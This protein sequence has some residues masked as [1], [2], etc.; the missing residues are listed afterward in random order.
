VQGG[1]FFYGQG[2]FA[3]AQDL[4]HSYGFFQHL[5]ESSSRM[6]ARLPDWSQHDSLF[7]VGLID[8]A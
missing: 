3:S 5:S 7:D 1:S 4:D 6:D 2:L 8:T